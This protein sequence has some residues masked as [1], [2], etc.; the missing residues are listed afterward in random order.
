MLKS[1]HSL[2]R[3]LAVFSFLHIAQGG[4]VGIAVYG[5]CQTGCNAA[6]VPCVAAA[7]GIAGVVTA[8]VGIPAAVIAC[9]VAQGA[10]MAA[11]AAM[12][13]SPL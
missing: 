6:W 4:I 1:V 13:L 9:S 5:V 3:L 7:G 12:A 8:G 2:L 10:C 11:C